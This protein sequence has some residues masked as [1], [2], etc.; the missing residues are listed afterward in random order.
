MFC[1]LGTSKIIAHG[2]SFV[3]CFFKIYLNFFVV[4]FLLTEVVLL[5]TIKANFDGKRGVSMKRSALKISVTALSACLICVCSWIAVPIGGVPMTLQTFGVAFC[6]YLLGARLGVC[7]TAVYLMLGA[8]GLPV[9]AG[10]GG[11]LAFF[12]GPTGG[13]LVGF[14][15]LALFCGIASK[16]K[17]IFVELLFVLSGLISCHLLGV[18]WF[19]YVSTVSP[20]QAF[21]LTSLP[22][23]LKDVI[24][25]LMARLLVRKLIKRSRG[26]AFF[27]NQT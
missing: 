1:G 6:G 21:L 26:L 17:R 12:V 23:I 24:S 8:I 11:S 9:F 2:F 10:F 4:E 3:K 13:F 14:L 16:R 22:Y 18:F 19:G 7:A 15:L 20:A 5:G 27:R 25:V